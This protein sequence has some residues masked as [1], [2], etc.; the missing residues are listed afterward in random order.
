MQLAITALSE[1]STD[2]LAELL[3]ATRDS[4]CSIV[5]IRCSSLAQTRAAYLL[6]QGNW[7]QI[8]KLEH[9]LESLRKHFAVQIQ[10]LRTEPES[11][12]K[13]QVAI[14]YILESFSL[15]KDAVI[16]SLS[17]FLGDQGVNIEEITGSSYQ[18][19]YNQAAVFA[20]RFVLLIPATIQLMAL[21]EDLLDY[22]DQLNI[23][24][25]FEPIKR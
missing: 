2:Y 9:A 24:A 6:V 19:A 17:A 4:K 23:D 18:A 14:P 22:C 10:S 5:E 11:K 3:S 15:D 7:N 25:L 20:I 16:E 21:R 12:N 8:A 13:S 1:L